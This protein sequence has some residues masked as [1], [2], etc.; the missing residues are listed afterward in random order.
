MKLT[1]Q[2]KLFSDCDQEVEFWLVSSISI[3]FQSPIF[4][5]GWKGVQRP[6]CVIVQKID[7]SPK[8]GRPVAAAVKPVDETHRK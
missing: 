8:D 2:S 1:A 3:F 4:V 6:S 5:F 7:E